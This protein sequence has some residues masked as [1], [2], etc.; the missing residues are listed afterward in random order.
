MRRAW[1]WWIANLMRSDIITI[2]QRPSAHFSQHAPIARGPSRYLGDHAGQSGEGVRDKRLS[3]ESIPVLASN[4]GDWP[5]TTRPRT[6]PRMGKPLSFLI[7]S[8]ICRTRVSQAR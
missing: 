7:I 4:D 5:W 2:L 1:H 8:M 6:V 3:A